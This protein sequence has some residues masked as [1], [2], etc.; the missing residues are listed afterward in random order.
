MHNLTIARTVGVDRKGGGGGGCGDCL[1]YY[2]HSGNSRVTEGS[3]R[4]KFVKVKQVPT[5][6]VVI[7]NTF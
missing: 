7:G 2:H 3:F 1:Y 6:K 4:Q 5:R